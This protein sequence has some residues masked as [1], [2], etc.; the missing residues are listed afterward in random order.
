LVA[1]YGRITDLAAA[2]CLGVSGVFDGATSAAVRAVQEHAHITQD[3][4]CG[5]L[6]WGV[7]ITGAP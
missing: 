5:P 4:I 7:L 1:E 2:A 3:G 6:T